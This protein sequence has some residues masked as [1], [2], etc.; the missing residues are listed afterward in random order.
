MSQDCYGLTRACFTNV[1]KAL[2]PINLSPKTVVLDG[3]DSEKITPEVASLGQ[4]T[5]PS[6]SPTLY[7]PW[8]TIVY[9]FL[10]FQRFVSFPEIQKKINTFFILTVETFFCFPTANERLITTPNSLVKLQRY[11][12]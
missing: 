2:S 7:R 10:H 11:V 6:L 4:I 8:T 1:L 9:L 5:D 3:V 12:R